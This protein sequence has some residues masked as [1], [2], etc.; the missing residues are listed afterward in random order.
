MYFRRQW[1]YFS[2]GILSHWG[3]PAYETTVERTCE[4]KV[5]VENG[6][7]INSMRDIIRIPYRNIHPEPYLQVK[8]CVAAIKYN[9]ICMQTS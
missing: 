1:V 7:P 8:K 3:K 9:N 6:T 4:I 2:T 5:L